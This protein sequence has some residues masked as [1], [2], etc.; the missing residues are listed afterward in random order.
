MC[1]L[2]GLL[3]LVPCA[4][5]DYWL[6]TLCVGPGAAWNGLN[7]WGGI[8]VVHPCIWHLYVLL[9][10]PP[11]SLLTPCRFIRNPW[12]WLV[13]YG[14]LLQ[15]PLYYFHSTYG[16]SRGRP[17][18]WNDWVWYIIGGCPTVRGVVQWCNGLVLVV[19][20]V[21]GCI[22]EDI[23]KRGDTI[24]NAVFGGYYWGSDGLAEEFH[25]IGDLFGLGF[26]WYNLLAMIMIKGYPYNPSLFS[27][28][29]PWLAIGCLPLNNGCTS[30]GS[31]MGGLILKWA[32]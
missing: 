4:Q 3:Q 27:S 24:D 11:R 25:R 20:L 32:L 10:C 16:L 19:W 6:C 31:N 7:F 15:L 12:S 21:R 1:D 17:L 22:H 18:D 30:N 5:S 8:F 9:D 13:G 14:G 28:K 29:V 26:L 2:E 23:Y